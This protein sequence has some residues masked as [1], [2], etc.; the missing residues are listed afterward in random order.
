MTARL[1]GARC[2]VQI[3]IGFG[4]AVTPG[5]ENVQYPVI[6]EDMPQPQLAQVVSRAYLRGHPRRLARVWRE[7]VRAA[8]HQVLQPPELLLGVLDLD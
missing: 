2:P 6:L 4:D 8:L 3:D 7:P 1:D 5:P